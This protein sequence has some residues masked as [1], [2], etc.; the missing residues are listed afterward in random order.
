ALRG[1]KPQ[2]LEQDAIDFIAEMMLETCT[3]HWY[4][5][6]VEAALKKD[7]LP[8]WIKKTKDGRYVSK[9]PSGL[10]VE[11]VYVPAGPF[12]LGAEGEYSLPPQI[13]VL[14]KGFWMDK[15]PV[16]NEQYQHFLKANPKHRSPNMKKDWAK[17]YNWKGC[18][19]PKGAEKHPVVLVSWDDAQAFCKWAGKVLP[20]E[21]QWEKAGRGVD[22]RCWPW[23]NEW[24]LANCNS[25]SFWAKRD[26]WDY[27]KDWK[28]WWEKE[29]PQQFAGKPMTTPVGQFFNQ[30]KIESPYGCVDSAG[31][32][33]EWCED[34][35]D[36]KQNTRVLR[37][38]AWDYDP[39]N[40]ACAYR[41]SNDAGN[42][43]DNVGFRCA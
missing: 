34:F 19:F 29:Y 38:G 31:N 32:V 12:V 41:G 6:P 14:E 9:L 40:V 18:D 8:D 21:Q 7:G 30:Q 42:R 35:Y 17:P 23:G 43:D 10:E 27:E 2:P 11:M 5:Q 3:T 26:L 15:A 4:R 22:A 24:N 33:W 1:A 28:P 39:H 16:T 37:G 36:E 25:A 20:T 13:A